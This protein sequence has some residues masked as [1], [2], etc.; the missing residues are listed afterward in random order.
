MM[1]LGNGSDDVGTDDGDGN[2]NND[3]TYMM[4]LT[5]QYKYWFDDFFNDHD[6]AK[7]RKRSR[8]DAMRRYIYCSIS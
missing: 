5:P 7:Q 2:N 6:D 4:V 8:T 3:A 1:K